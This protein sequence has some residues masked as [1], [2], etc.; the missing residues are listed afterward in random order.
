MSVTL[1]FGLV[2][3]HDNKEPFRVRLD[4]DALD[5]LIADARNA[6]R[7]YELR[8]IQ[9]P[10]DIWDYVHVTPEAVPAALGTRIA[11]AR[12]AA[13]IRFVAEHPWPDGKIPF[14]AFDD[15]FQPVWAYDPE[16]LDEAWRGRWLGS[17]VRELFETAQAALA[18]LDGGDPLV[19]R[20]LRLARERN[21][22]LDELSRA[23]ALKRQRDRFHAP[24][25][26]VHGDGFYREL[27]RLLGDPDLVSIAC[28]GEGDWRLLRLLCTEQRRRVDATGYRPLHALFIS[29]LGDVHP[30]V[31]GWGGE[32]MW[33]SEGLAHGDLLIEDRPNGAPVKELI[34]HYRLRPQTVL[35][36][37]NDAQIDGYRRSAGDGWVRYDRIEA[38][39][40]RPRTEFMA[41]RW[42]GDKRPVIAF[43]DSGASVFPHEH[44]LV[45]VGADVEDTALGVL[46]ELL[47]DWRQRGNVPLVVCDGGSARAGVAALGKVVDLSDAV[48]SSGPPGARVTAMLRDRMPWIDVALL[49]APDTGLASAVAEHL[50]SQRRPWQPWIAATIGLT[51]IPVDHMIEGSLTDALKQAVEFARNAQPYRWLRL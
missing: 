12:A 13:K 35:A 51:G 21:H 8:L 9:R 28:R 7:V 31:A 19:A 50:A 32:V 44:A 25:A 23:D 47:A 40:R 41:A 30:A 45:V 20:E 34:E 1:D 46:G 6:W 2:G 48:D 17:Y 36:D 27:E 38:T 3:Y 43:A 11:E 18:D 10:G 5:A 42:P 29:I 49:L 16:P 24:K 39:P 22:Q 14:A 37:A 15:L 4:S 26:G 33:F